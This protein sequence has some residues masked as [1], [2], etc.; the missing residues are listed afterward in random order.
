MRYS[1]EKLEMGFILSPTS[2]SKTRGPVAQL[3]RASG[4]GPEGWGFDSL[5]VH[6]FYFGGEVAQL[7]EQ[8]TENPCVTGPTP[9]LATTPF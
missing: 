7:V 8:R 2:K 1:L 5:R 3:D 4:Y 9:V 6:H